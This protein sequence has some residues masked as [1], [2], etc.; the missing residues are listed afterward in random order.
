MVTSWAAC[1]KE[2]TQSDP[3]RS[4]GF[5]RRQG[6]LRGRDSADGCAAHARVEDHDAGVSVRAHRVVL[7]VDEGA[8]SVVAVIVV[9]VSGGGC[10]R[11]AEDRKLRAECQ[12]VE[13]S[14][15]GERPERRLL[16]LDERIVQRAALPAGARRLGVVVVLRHDAGA[17]LERHP[18][19]VLLHVLDGRR[20][21]TEVHGRAS[22]RLLAIEVFVQVAHDR[23]GVSARGARHVLDTARVTVKHRALHFLVVAAKA[24][25][26]DVGVVVNHVVPGAI[27]LATHHQLRM[28]LAN[29]LDDVHKAANTDCGCELSRRLGVQGGARAAGSARARA[30]ACGC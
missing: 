18:Q 12:P 29:P 14:L 16:A 17:R 6:I 27:A 15:A 13:G 30:S 11:G 1:R 7:K 22:A 10:A 26:A 8:A 2:K 4:R 5:A 3:H 19:L 21:V 24:L 25:P 20:H 9:V 23:G 28:L